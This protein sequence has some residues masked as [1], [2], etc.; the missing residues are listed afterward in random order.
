MSLQRPHAPHPQILRLA[1]SLFALMLVLTACGT[2]DDA[3]VVDPADDPAEPAGEEVDPAGDTVAE[4]VDL[5][6][7][8]I[9]VGSK[10][11]TEQQIVGQLAVLALEA[12]GA[13]V[14]DQTGL[15]GTEVV[16]NSLTT[17]EIDAYWEYTGT[18]WI[19]IL[20]NE[21]VLDGAEAY[22]TAV[23]DAD[24]ENEIVWLPTSDVNNT[25]AFFYG[26]EAGLEPQ[27]ISDLAELANS[28]PVVLCAAA[29]F[30]TRPDGLPGV[31]ETYG[32]EFSDVVELDLSLAISAASDGEEC[33]IG[34]IFQT[35]PLIAAND[36][37]VLEDDQD[38]FPVYNL[39]MTMREETYSA[40]A[41]AY[42]TLFGAITDLLDNETM[43]ELNGAVDIDAENPADV[44]REFLVDNGII[45][46]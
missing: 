13:T 7:V 16:R 37:T 39:G 23:R 14:D 25:Y 15:S 41:E 1:I 34:E 27:S 4:S 5:S 8:E 30:I 22:F 42:D 38:F 17:G 40:N 24:A 3:T 20:G 29:E 28:E 18:G 35:D 2:E 36:L 19:T 9:G 10:E 26:P 21:E 11:F 6:G 12:A 32:F 43:T 44:A 31:T 45:P 33:A 46:G